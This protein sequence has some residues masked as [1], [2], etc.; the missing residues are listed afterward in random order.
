M[1]LFGHWAASLADR[2]DEQYLPDVKQTVDMIITTVSTF[3][4]LD[5]SEVQERVSTF[6][7]NYHIL[8]LFFRL[9]TQIS[10]SNSFAPI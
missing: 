3:V 5:D 7:L 9:Q 2:W 4:G 10:S 1:K 8:N 6:D